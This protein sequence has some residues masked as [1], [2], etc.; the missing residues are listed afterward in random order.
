MKNI[1]VSS[2]QGGVQH[3]PILR[4]ILQ[5][6]CIFQLHHQVQSDY[7]IQLFKVPKCSVESIDAITIKLTGDT[8]TLD[9]MKNCYFNPKCVA[10]TENVGNHTCSLHVNILSLVWTHQDKQGS[11]LWIPTIF[12]RGK[13]FYAV[14]FCVHKQFTQWRSPLSI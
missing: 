10:V 13:L 9:C 7:D 8:P 5:L 6:L 2:K 12:S 3:V 1:C 11:Q 4:M 14:I